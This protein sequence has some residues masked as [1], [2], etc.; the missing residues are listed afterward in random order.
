M[1]FFFVFYVYNKDIINDINVHCTILQ[2]AHAHSL[3]S[4]IPVKV[5]L[6]TFFGYFFMVYQT[7]QIWGNLFSSLGNIFFH[8]WHQKTAKWYL[9]FIRITF[10]GQKSKL[11][12]NEIFSFSLYFCSKSLLGTFFGLYLAFLMQL[13]T[14]YVS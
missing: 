6:Q 1:F 2:A 8:F 13:W 14:I 12:L 10:P 11:M 7:G 4:K 5:L 3:I 9:S